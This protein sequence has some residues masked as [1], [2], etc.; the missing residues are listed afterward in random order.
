MA[1]IFVCTP[2]DLMPYLPPPP[3]AGWQR[4][5]RRG[6]A[7]YFDP[8]RSLCWRWERE[9]GTNDADDVQPQCAV[10]ARKRANQIRR[11]R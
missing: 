11:G 3:A 8:C 4:V 9:T 1:E 2:A 5:G 10:C 7:H 6:T